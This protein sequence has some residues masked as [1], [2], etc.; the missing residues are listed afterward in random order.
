MIDDLS[1]GIREAKRGNTV[2]GFELLKGYINTNDFPEAKAWFGYCLAKEKMDIPLGI[3]HCKDALNI[4]P[5]LSDVYLAS[6]RI[7][8]FNGQR[9]FAIDALQQG[10]KST[11]HEEISNMIKQLGVRKK[12]VVPY[13][14]RDNFI[15][16]SLGRLL[17]S[18]GLRRQ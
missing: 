9:K 1:F 10:M 17:T 4:D 12:P 6:A 3:S 11:P 18:V 16:V 13:V 14:S 2:L 8:L 5:N 15:N 7:Y